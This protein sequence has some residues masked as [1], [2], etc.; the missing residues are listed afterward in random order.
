M[1][2]VSSREALFCILREQRM[3]KVFITPFTLDELDIMN[4]A[5]CLC[6]A[7]TLVVRSCIFRVGQNRIHIHRVRPYIW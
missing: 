2:F 4:I 6:V 5:A 3:C 7:D 1:I